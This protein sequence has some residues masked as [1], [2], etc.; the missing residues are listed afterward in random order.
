M[1][2]EMKLSATVTPT[3]LSVKDDQEENSLFAAVFMMR[4]GLFL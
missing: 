4:G 1:K 3:V 2:K